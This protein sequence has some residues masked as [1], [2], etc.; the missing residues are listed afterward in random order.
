MF[1]YSIQL[2]KAFSNSQS[3]DLKNDN[4]MLNIKWN[5][6]LTCRIK[7]AITKIIFITSKEIDFVGVNLQ[8]GAILEQG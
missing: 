4:L 7:K 1:L 2:S 8:S 5:I 3:N 6:I